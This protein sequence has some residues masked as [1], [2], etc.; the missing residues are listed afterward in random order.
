MTNPNIDLLSGST[1]QNGGDRLV[2]KQYTDGSWGWPLN[3]PPTYSNILGPIAKGLV[4]AYNYTFSASQLAAIVKSKT[5]L[6]NKTNNFSV[7]DGYLAKAID[8]VLGGTTCRDYVNANFYGLLALGTYKGIYSTQSYIQKII[9]DRASWGQANMAAWDIGMGLVGAASCGVSGTELNYWKDGTKTKINELNTSDFYDVIGLA[10]ALYGLAFVNEPFDPTAGSYSSASSIQD[11]AVILQSYQISNGGF[12]WYPGSMTIGDQT[13]Q[14]TCYAILA[15]S[16]VSRLDYIT[17]ILGAADYLSSVQLSSGG[18]DNYFGDPDGENN[19]LTGEAL[20][21][22]TEAYRPAGATVENYTQGSWHYTIQEAI[23]GANAGDVIKVYPGNYIETASNSYLYSSQG[24]YTF[25]LFL[26]NSK[27]G[28]SI[29][30]VDEYGVPIDNYDAIEA[31]VQLNATNDFGPSGVFVEGNDITISGLKLFLDPSGSQNKTVEVIGENVTVKYCKLT[32]GNS[33]YINDWRYNSISNTSYITKYWIEGNK[34]E[35]GTSLDICSGAG[36][37]GI[38]ADRK[39]LNNYFDAGATNWAMISFTGSETGVPWFLYSVGGANISGNTFVNGVQY[40]RHRGTL[41]NSQFDWS[42]YWNDNTFDKA[43]ITLSNELSFTPRDYSYL[44]GGVTFNNCMRIGAI[45]QSDIQNVALSGDIINVADGTYKEQL[46]ITKGLSLI[47]DIT[48]PDNVVIDGENKTTLTSDGQVR[49][50]NPTGAVVFKGFK[51]INGGRSSVGGNYMILTK[52]SYS[53]TIQNCKLIGHGSGLEPGEDYGIWAY[54]GNGDLIIKD[55]YFTDMY[56]AI[57]IEK[58]TGA[59][60]IE[61]NNFDNL[62]TPYYAPYSGDVGGRAIEAIT[63]GGTNITSLQKVAGNTFTNFRSTGVIFSGGFG[64]SGVGK[65]TNVVIE[66]NDFTFAS[67]DIVNNFGAINLRNVSTSNSDPNG[68]VTADIHNNTINVPSS[69]GI[70]ISGLNGAT[71]IHDNSILG[72]PYGLKADEALGTPI[73]ATCNWWGTSVASEVAAKISGSA[74]YIPFNISDGGACAGGMPVQVVHGGVVV[75]GHTTIQAGVN[76]AISGDVVT[77]AAGT[78]N[79][80]VGI[81]TGITLYGPNAGID[82]NTGIRGAEAIISGTGGLRI[83]ISTTDPVVVDGFTLSSLAL[84]SYT[85]NTQITYQNNIIANLPG[86][87]FF[88]APATYDLKY[89]HIY[90]TAT[91]W[92]ALLLAGNWNGTTGTVVDIEGN[93]LDNASTAAGLNLSS[94]SGTI[95]GNIFSGIAYYGLLLANETNVTVDNN[96][97]TNIVNPNPAGSTTWGAGVR[98]FTPLTNWGVNLNGNSFTNCYVGFGIREGSSLTSSQMTVTGNTFTSNTYDIINQGTPSTRFNPDGTNVFDGVTLSSATTS[99]LL[100]LADKVLD[101]VDVPTYGYVSLKTGNVYVTA[102]SFFAPT[103]T[104]PSIQRGINIATTNDVVNVGA[105]TYTEQLTINKAM[106]VTGSDGA[107][108][109]GT[110]L[111]PTWTTGLKITSGNVTFNNIDVNNFTQDGIT[112]YNNI[113]MPNIHITNCKISNIQPGNWGFGIYIGYESEGF[114]YLPPDI[115]TFLD[116]SGLLIENNE[117]TNTHSSAL[118]LQAI[119]G[120]QGTLQIRNNNIHDNITNDGIWIDCARNLTIEDNIINGNKWGIELS[121]Y[122]DAFLGIIGGDWEYDWDTRFLN[123]DYGPKDITMSGNTI[124]NSLNFNFGLWDGWPST[125]YLNDNNI[126]GDVHAVNNYLPEN[127]DA[128]CNWYGTIVQS[129]IAAKISG[130]VTYIPYNVSDGGACAGGLPVQVVRAGIIVS[131]HNTIQ[132]GIN[133]SLIGDVIEVAAGTYTENVVVNK[134]VTI[135]GAGQSNTFVIPALSAPNPCAGSSLCGGSASNIFLIQANNVTIQ[136][137]TADGNNTAINSGVLSNGVD[138]DARNGIITNHSVGVYN[139]LNVNHVTVKNIYLRGIYA[140]AGGTFDFQDNTVINV[141]GE[142][143]SIGI[144][145]FG[146]AGLIKSNNISY[147]NDAICS[148]YSTGT[149]YW[150]NTITHSGSGIHSDNNG[151]YGGTADIIRNNNVSLGTTNAYGIWVFASHFNNEVYGNAINGVYIGL[152]VAGQF[153]GIPV[154][155]NNTV[156]N[157]SYGVYST[158]SLFGWGSSACTAT[159]TNNSIDNCTNEGFDIEAESGYISTIT[160][161]GNHITG[162]PVNAS[163]YISGTGTLNVDMTCNWWGTAIESEVSAKI[164]GDITYIPYSVSDGGACAGGLPVLVVRSG[165]IVSGHSTIQPAIDVAIPGDEI[166]IYPGVYNTGSY[167][168]VNKQDIEITGVD[169][170][171]NPIT[172][173]DDVLATVG[174]L[175]GGEAN[176]V[177]HVV[178]S[179][180][181]INGLRISDMNDKAMTINGDNFTL[182]NCRFENQWDLSGAIYFYDATPGIKSDINKSAQRAFTI[183]GNVIKGWGVA[184]TDGT[185]CGWPASLRVISDNTF[186]ISSIYPGYTFYSIGFRSVNGSGWCNSPVGGATIRDNNFEDMG[187]RGYVWFDGQVPAEGLDFADILANNSFSKGAAMAFIGTTNTP[188]PILPSDPLYNPVTRPNLVILRNVISNEILEAQSGDIIKV[189]PGIYTEQLHVTIPNLTIQGTSK[190]EV[191]IKSPATLSSYFTSGANNNYPVVFID[192]GSGFTLKNVTV[193]GD[194]KGNANYRFQGIGFWNAGG[195]VQNVDVI[196]VMDNTFSGAQHGVGIYAYNNTSTPTY[197]ITLDNINVT[198]FQKTAI[199]LNGDGDLTVDLDNVTT[200][201]KGATGVTAQNGIQVWGASGTINDCNISQIAYTGSGWTASGLLVNGPGTITADNVDVDHCQTSVYWGDADGTYQNSSITNPYQ[202]GIVAFSTSPSGHAFSLDETAVA[203]SN[204][205][206]YVGVFQYSDAGGVM[207]MT[208]TNSLINNWDYGVYAYNYSTSG[209]DVNTV[210]HSNNISSNGYGFITAAIDDQSAENNYWGDCPGNVLYGYYSDINYF[211][212][213]TTCSGTPGGFTFGGQINNIAASATV[214]PICTGSST[215]IYATGGS[216]YLW[217]HALGSGSSKVVSPLATTTYNVTGKDAHGCTGAFAAVTVNVT[218]LP[219]VLIDGSS[220]GSS[221]IVLGNSKILTATGATSYLWSTGSTADHI[222]VSPISSTAYTVTGTTGN[223]SATATHLVNVIIV[224]AGSNQ[225]IC[226]GGSASLTAS[227]SGIGGTPSY[228]WTPGDIDHQTITVYPAS[229]TTYTVT[230]NGN[231]EF[232]AHVTVFVNPKPIANAGPDITIVTTG[233][234]TGSASGGTAPY[235]YSW[236]GPGVFVST[237]Q[238]PVV[239]IAGT[240]T[241]TVTDAFG[242]ISNADQAIV[243]VAS[244]GYPVSGNISY[245]YGIVNTQM[246]NV[247]V[248]LKQGGVTKYMAITPATGAGNYQFPNVASG[249]YDVYFSLTTAWGGVTTADIIAIQNHYRPVGAIPLVGIKRLAADVVDNST[250]AIVLVNDRNKVNDKRV[251]PSVPFATGDWVF[252]RSEDIGANAVPFTYANSAGTTYITIT[253]T[254]VPVVQ[255]FKSLCYGDVD[256]SYTG[257]K[258]LEEQI[259]NVNDCN[260]LDLT[261]FPN[262]F[263]GQTTIQ[264]N[265]PVEAT[266]DIIIVDLLGNNVAR[267]QDPDMYEGTHSI[268]FNGSRLSSGLYFYTVRL[269]TSDDILIQTGKMI[270]NK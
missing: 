258:E 17:N 51:I 263:A 192:G 43:V 257:Y 185:G 231:P 75:S 204:N 124:E 115:N 214:N 52:G 153:G 193:D 101:A 64:G 14:E 32:D 121:S 50:Y 104:A 228:L 47:G 220:S 226:Q 157:A 48:T 206:G 11:L 244:G 147:A 98:A 266:A 265:M 130:D 41:D 22:Y 27:P 85:A 203:G 262:P 138:V 160:A 20:W 210:V 129:E 4:Q 229:T 215:T 223:C 227:V 207:N 6:L 166:H 95:T 136:N 140:S 167:I 119:T 186:G 236:T 152:C 237:L 151:G 158:T 113:D 169:E 211:P 164:S 94:V 201:G 194:K 195:T 68:G 21:G 243:T 134:E 123:S 131:G 232:H 239:S 44:S 217:D 58:I 255:D 175:T 246:H 261:N 59:L 73:T 63:Y 242:C 97:F 88:N 218:P 76:A 90:G 89:N 132:A 1:I 238:R 92:D 3:A 49:I 7:G 12:T 212:Y 2:E 116:F 189:D 25:G 197:S 202:H 148:N 216:D 163:A 65:Y 198:D 34:F 96:Q 142:S 108:L 99:Q 86:N 72:V 135:N 56:H 245:A 172:S 241:L 126:F 122:G 234:L 190:N 253:V 42:S 24:P 179:N 254:A 145:N 79:E 112:A 256:A 143:Q 71:T 224:S 264:Y 260:G 221:S 62:Y 55:S 199:A 110:G 13:N 178:A 200:A 270:I 29:I 176:M 165:V 83:R 35:F 80:D 125:I 154:F 18:W 60:T 61:T 248:T 67:S 156:T 144:M 181:T 170:S 33:L 31:N 10:G 141:A 84:D 196:N 69:S 117:I 19:E 184:I 57:L 259:V 268:I 105:G 188:R 213:H 28:I 100:T 46:N 78:Y 40:I 15:L 233:T 267:I 23:N 107:I 161:H 16:Q 155:S 173:A 39:I 81:N 247:T 230:V 146:G 235:S 36:K 91:D 171:G 54:T 103:T 118:V 37:S 139:N 249:T 191:T 38:V 66:N 45:I 114:K 26:P 87:M 162:N 111:I 168:T 219:V 102:N 252:T 177:F 93:V 137:L 269:K 82:P 128:T 187:S 225:S 70:Q 149:T 106:T 180:V 133:A 30:G 174:P 120:T 240:Y 209:G 77:V 109:S 222:T 183:T 182:T 208:I 5:F 74:T 205:P 8:E 251:N 9:D 53:K 150:S 159:F 127:L 250:N